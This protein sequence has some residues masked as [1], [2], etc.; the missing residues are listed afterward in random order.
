MLTG[1]I[2]EVDWRIDKMLLIFWLRASRRSVFTYFHFFFFNSFFVVAIDFDVIHWLRTTFS[3][4]G[5]K[6]QLTLKK[7]NVSSP[8]FID[9]QVSIYTVSTFHNKWWVK[10]C[11]K[12]LLLQL[13]NDFFHKKVCNKWIC[14]KQR[15]TKIC[16]E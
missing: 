4:F 13:T 3:F 9:F 12:Y 15:A 8:G 2:W 14:N 16:N 5:L 10:I 6:K 11:G 7:L 1:T